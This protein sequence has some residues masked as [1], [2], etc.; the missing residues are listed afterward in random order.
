MAKYE[1]EQNK[2]KHRVV[3]YPYTIEG[4]KDYILDK[5][6]FN[7]R[8][9]FTDLIADRPNKVAVIFNFLAILELLQSSLISITVGEGFNNFW[10]EKVEQEAE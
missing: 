9:P 4:Q 8:L 5:V 1:L 3:Q 2:P 6:A 10:L 7:S